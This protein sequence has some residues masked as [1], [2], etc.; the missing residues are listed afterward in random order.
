MKTSLKTCLKRI[1]EDVQRKHLAEDMK[2]SAIAWFKR[3]E[4]EQAGNKSIY[5]IIVDELKMQ[6][7]MLSG[8]NNKIS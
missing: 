6:T 4:E 5:E 1:E 3:D 7:E 8:F 2:K